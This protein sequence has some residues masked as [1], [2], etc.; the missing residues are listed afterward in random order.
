VIPGLSIKPNISPHS[1]SKLSS[2]SQ[3]FVQGMWNIV[4]SPTSQELHA[5]SMISSSKGFAV[6]SF[7]TILEWNGNTWSIVASPTTNHLF[8]VILLSPTDGW[9]VGT[10]G[11]IIHW[12]GTI[13]SLA[14]SPTTADLFAVTMETGGDGWIGGRGTILR[15]TENSWNVITS[16]TT[17]ALVSIDM[18]SGTDGWAV[19]EYST[20][21]RWDGS[22]WLVQNF[23]LAPDQFPSVDAVATNDVWLAGTGGNIYHWDGSTWGL[24]PN[25]P[26]NYPLSD[27]DM[28]AADNGWLVGSGA[29][30][31]WDGIEWSLIPPPTPNTLYSIDMLSKSDGWTVGSFGTILRYQP[32]A[33]DLPIDYS[34]TSFAQA[35]LGNIG[36]NSG[37]VNSWFDHT[38]PTYRRAPNSGTNNLTR[39]FGVYTGTAPVDL[40][41]CRIYEQS[42]YDGHNGID[43]QKRTNNDLI[44]AAAPG[45][46][47]NTIL[48]NTGY[49][50]RVWIDH[51]NGYATLYGHLRSISVTIGT[52]IT[53]TAIQPLGIMGNT[54]VSVGETGIHLH[55]GL[56]YDRNGNGWTEDEAV[57]PYGWAVGADP[58]SIATP[59]MQA[60]CVAGGYL[61]KYHLN[62]LQAVSNVGGSVTSPSGRTTIAVPQGAL[63]STLTLDLWDTPAVAG[64]S[65]QLRS[66][67]RSFWFRVLEWL[68][69]EGTNGSV[70]IVSSS[71]AQPIT[72]TI[73][74]SDTELLHL[75]E[76]QLTIYRWNT[77]S[78]SWAAL[79]TT[80]NMGQNL[81]VAQTTEIGNFDLQAPML[82]PADILEP[83]DNYYAASL[84]IP[85]IAPEGQLFDIE[86]DEDWF[87][88]NTIAGGQY[89]ITT[90]SLTSGTDTVIQLYNQD[91]VTVLASDDNSGGGAASQLLWQAPLSGMSGTYFVRVSQA[92][93]SAY[94]CNAGY[95]IGV[96]QQLQVYLPLIRR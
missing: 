86:Q 3:N 12:D 94:G 52:E 5:V 90:S 71:F 56:Y 74:Y 28:L 92:G 63:S 47:T 32:L 59:Q 26:S 78:D 50:N 64:A 84:L 34:G 54:G 88:L 25:H 55:F 33:L 66:T 77:N 51:R 2:I 48:S 69:G 16:P 9:A 83:N 60:T 45:V 57:D 70:S 23:P 30:F 41:N 1:K 27:F 24:A 46:V 76:S 79:Q 87:R 6:G 58:C 40:D 14:N 18:L 19:G 82:C 65:A 89:T 22:Q 8:S 85:N 75:N 17:N 7:G 38:Y 96:T 15:W 42:C 67:G 29:I 68:S 91:G 36:Q 44:F 43:F 80:V 11:T 93:G 53:N 35:A 73:A 62:A 37:R 39:W 72:V 95:D 13:W 10:Y 49:G 61:W 4:S 31:H 81:A 20:I 21:L